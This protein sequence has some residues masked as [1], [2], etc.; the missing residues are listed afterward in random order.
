MKLDDILARPD[1]RWLDCSGP[2]S[3]YVVSTR[4]RLARNMAGVPF[5][6]RA[7]GQSADQVFTAAREACVELNRYGHFASLGLF[8]I[9]DLSPLDRRVLVEKHLMSMQQLEPLSRA[10]LIVN[11]DE[12]VSVMVNEEDHFRIQCLAS[13]LDLASTLESARRLDD[14]IEE[15]VDYAY[16]SRF[17]YLTACPTNVGTG[18]RASLMMHLPGL[19][20]SGQ[21]G[22]VVG[23]MSKLGVVVRGFYG[24]GTE[25][26]GNLFQISNQLTFGQAEDEIIHNLELMVRQIIQQEETARHQLLQSKRPAVE[27][28]VWRSFGIL[29]H[30][31]V[32]SWEEASSLISDVRLGVDLGLLDIVDPKTLNRL[33][34][35]VRPAFVQRMSGRELTPAERRIA[36]ADMVRNTLTKGIR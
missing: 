1:S 35:G 28:R 31:R 33:T 25:A 5:P 7:S 22:P 13:G 27:D 36:R 9:E 3:R 26:T 12:L 32:L 17:G 11:E 15:K 20:H 6:H 19:V 34:I 16:D 4:I 2:D 30:A 23:A 21:L 29:Y 10:A 8:A 24:E 14:V 18:L